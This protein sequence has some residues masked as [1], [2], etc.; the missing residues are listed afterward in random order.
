MPRIFLLQQELLQQQEELQ[1]GSPDFGDKAADNSRLSSAAGCGSSFFFDSAPTNS[2]WPPQSSCK[3]IENEITNVETASSD[4]QDDLILDDDDSNESDIDVIDTENDLSDTLDNINVLETDNDEADVEIM[5]KEEGMFLK[6]IYD[7][8]L[9]TFT[10][11]IVLVT[12]LLASMR[13]WRNCRKIA[14]RERG[15][16]AVYCKS[17]QSFIIMFSYSL[18]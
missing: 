9:L 11:Y 2:F 14:E 10:V 1:L 5:E 4:L 15:Q 13:G 16:W 12:S 18:A 7:L 3:E 8:N 17:P 6:S